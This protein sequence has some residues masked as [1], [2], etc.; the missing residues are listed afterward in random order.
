M[1]KPKSTEDKAKK[2]EK[3][4][5]REQ[6]ERLFKLAREIRKEEERKERRRRI[7]SAIS[8]WG[9]YFIGILWLVTAVLGSLAKTE[10]W[11][12]ANIIGSIWILIGVISSK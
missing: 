1:K 10:D 12:L 7:T 9:P 6:Q 5:L 8:H 3:E 2:T 4:L 11:M